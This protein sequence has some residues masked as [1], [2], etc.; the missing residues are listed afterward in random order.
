MTFVWSANMAI[1]R[2]ALERVG[3]FDETIA[4]RG[5]EEDWL[6]RY[7][8]AGGI[9]RYVADAG[10]EH[11]RSRE[12]SALRR[13]AR[14]S[15]GHGRAARR[16]DDRK[17]TAPPIRGELRVLTG[18]AWHTLRRRCAYGVVMGAHTAGRLRQAL[19]D[20]RA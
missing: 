13:L 7:R 3:A 12:D 18:C 4:V 5:D 10:L 9:V 19:A 16:Y 6:R 8:A 14:A 2:S 1:R 15:Y 11:R 20:R 17:G